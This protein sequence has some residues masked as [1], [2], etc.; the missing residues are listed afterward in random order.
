MAQTAVPAL[1]LLQVQ[2]VG[3]RPLEKFFMGFEINHGFDEN[4]L[5]T[6]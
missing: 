5:G 6:R 1:V 2:V 4:V 3:F